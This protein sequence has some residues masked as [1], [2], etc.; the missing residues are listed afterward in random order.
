MPFQRRIRV[1]QAAT[2]LMIP[3]CVGCPSLDRL[4]SQAPVQELKSA[5]ENQPYL[6]YVPSTYS[7]ER[8]MPL[9]V[10]CHGTWPYDTAPLQMREWAAF[11]EAR[12]IIVAAPTLRG[13]Q[14]DLPPPPDRQIALQRED[15]AHIL[16]IVSELKRRYRIA[17]HMVFMTGWSGGAYAV[18]HT[19]LKHP[20]VF[21][22]LFVQQGAFD[23]R[24]MA[25]VS[26][27][28]LDTWQSIRVEFGQADLIRD[29]SKACLK[30][31][32]DAGLYVEELESPGSHKRVDASVP[33]KYFAQVA[34]ER[35]WVRV[36]AR[37]PD[38]DDLL[39]VRYSLD[40]VPAVVRQKWFFGDGDESTEPSPTH[41][42]A[43][44]GTYE[45]NV[46]VALAN[47]KKYNRKRKVEVGRPLVE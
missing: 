26:P 23:A 18:L 40:A 35:L 2:L 1:L 19:G 30:W 16:D 46:N 21:R 28:R 27:E 9:V 41:R 37:N 14:S 24:F 38:P 44:P 39:A 15:E 10:L 33:W 43:R 29:Q 8:P 5:N 12:G 34:K 32:R 20:E 3:A 22:A 17:E 47:G 11:A 4:P 42:Y 7:D 45:V 31:L 13:V 6:L 25:D 36:H